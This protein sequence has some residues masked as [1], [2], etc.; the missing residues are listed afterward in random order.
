MEGLVDQLKV[1]VRGR[2]EHLEWMSPETKGKALE[3]LSLFGV[4]IGY[5]NKWRNYASLQIDSD[6]IGNV[7]RSGAYKW[8]RSLRKLGRPVDPEEWGMTP[9]TVNAYYS[10]TRNEIVFPAAILQ[11]PFFDPN[12]DMAANYCGSGRR[13]R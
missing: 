1:G 11:A 9:Q 12:A 13:V 3:K 10:S 7:R 8:A 5:P 6:L 4:K 2:I